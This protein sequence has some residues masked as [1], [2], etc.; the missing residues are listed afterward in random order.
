MMT[1]RP[2]PN[3]DKHGRSQSHVSCGF[4]MTRRTL[5]TVMFFL[6]GYM[7]TKSFSVHDLCLCFFFLR[8]GSL[9]KQR[10]SRG[11]LEFYFFF[12]SPSANPV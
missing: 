2:T 4:W 7:T 8:A 10:Y 1:R 11:V 12:F 5:R 6:Y 9:C 3:G